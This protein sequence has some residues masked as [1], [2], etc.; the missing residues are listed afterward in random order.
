MCGV[1]SQ[2]A[3]CSRA[4]VQGTVLTRG[5]AHTIH[6]C[7]FLELAPLLHAGQGFGM[8]GREEERAHVRAHAWFCAYELVFILSPSRDVAI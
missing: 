2:M 6:D 5:L 7:L 1:S 8:G 4:W 3:R